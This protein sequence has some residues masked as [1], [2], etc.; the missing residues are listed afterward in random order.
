[1]S[2]LLNSLLG[3]K[4]EEEKPAEVATSGGFSDKLGSVLSSV[5]RLECESLFSVSDTVG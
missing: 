3:F 2:G 5:R 1:M 4:K